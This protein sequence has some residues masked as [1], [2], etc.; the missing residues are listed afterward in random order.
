MYQYEREFRQTGRYTDG[1]A[2]TLD[3]PGAKELLKALQPRVEVGHQIDV[4]KL[5]ITT[6]LSRPNLVNTAMGHV[7]T[8]YTVFP[9]MQLSWWQ[10][11]TVAYTLKTHNKEALLA[12]FSP[13]TGI[14]TNRARVKDWP[15]V[16]WRQPVSGAAGGQNVFGYL[17]QL[18]RAYRKNQIDQRE[19]NGFFPYRV[20][21]VEEVAT[22]TPSQQFFLKH[23]VHYNIEQDNH[24]VLPLR[25]LSRPL[26][27][28]LE[29]LNEEPQRA[30]FVQSLLPKS[31]EPEIAALLNGYQL[32][33]RSEW[34]VGASAL[35]ARAQLQTWL[36][37]HPE[38][39]RTP[40]VILDRRQLKQAIET[41]TFPGLLERLAR[42]G[43]QARAL[44]RRLS[45]RQ[46]TARLYRYSKASY[47]ER[48]QQEA[49][50]TAVL[51]QLELIEQA[52]LSL[53]VSSLPD[54]V[55][56]TLAE[57][58]KTQKADLTL[59]KLGTQGLCCYLQ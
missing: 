44:L 41:N 21:T 13:T 53:T 24:Q 1:F 54:T 28:F 18:L 29:E 58:L 31:L 16:M 5:D 48:Y 7:G 2:V 42:E 11:K 25:N 23:G 45:F 22:L 12:T 4:D 52:E 19:Y 55:K 26:R 51:E 32:N 40:L 9:E 56:Q 30:T 8:V 37:Q 50:Y 20:N 35:T 14:P 57:K 43:E 33:E 59:A 17:P 49:E 3:E 39:C 27:R 10:N 15:Q 46:G 6:Y 34:V 38:L 47:E 36:E